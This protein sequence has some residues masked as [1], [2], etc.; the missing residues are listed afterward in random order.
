[1]IHRPVESEKFYDYVKE[2]SNIVFLDNSW[3]NDASDSV[4][5][6]RHQVSIYFPNADVKDEDD[7]ESFTTFAISFHDD[8]EME[9][10][11]NAEVYKS[12]EAVVTEL[13][14]LYKTPVGIENLKAEDCA[15]GFEERAEIGINLI[16]D[17]LDEMDEES[18]GG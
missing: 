17:F 11:Y 1:M 2:H 10:K 12:I 6:Q 5:N 13:N 14:K 15:P 8:E 4:Y 7:C 3:Q 16:D 18:N 9:E